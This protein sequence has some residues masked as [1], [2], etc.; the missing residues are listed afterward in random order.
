MK[1]CP[2]TNIPTLLSA[3]ACSIILMNFS[4]SCSNQILI[5]L[6][7]ST[8]AEGL[9]LHLYHKPYT[10]CET[11]N[12]LYC[13]VILFSINLWLF[14]S[15]CIPSCIQLLHGVICL[16]CSFSFSF[17]AGQPTQKCSLSSTIAELHILH[18]LCSTGRQAYLPISICN[19]AV[20]PLR[21][22]SGDLCAFTLVFCT[23]PSVS[24]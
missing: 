17:R 7:P 21:W 16:V 9:W 19:G 24:P 8:W 1:F 5:E 10:F 12:Q 20:P 11:Y 15:L 4:S 3:F 14:S 6:A 23:Y 22:A 13:V 18:V 2:G